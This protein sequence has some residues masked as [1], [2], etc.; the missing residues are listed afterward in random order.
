MECLDATSNLWK[1]PLKASHG[2]IH[3]IS[4]LVIR[5]IELMVLAVTDLLVF[6]V[7]ES[8]PPV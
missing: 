4:D 2:S 3:S 1:A 5:C 8:H 6:P 7:V